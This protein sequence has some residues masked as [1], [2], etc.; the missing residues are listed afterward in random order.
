VCG[1]SP[2]W[3]GEQEKGA[4]IPT[5]VSTRW[6]RGSDG[7]ALA[8]GGGGRASS[9]RR[10]SRREGEERRR[11][12]SAVWSG[13]DGAPFICSGRQWRGW[14]TLGRRRW[15]MEINSVRYEAKKRGGESTGWPVDEGKWR[16]REAI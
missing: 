8:K 13:R 6:Q 11:A 1:T 7:G 15:G 9:M 2:W 3:H 4:G 5:T 16:R 10:C 12:V 14:E